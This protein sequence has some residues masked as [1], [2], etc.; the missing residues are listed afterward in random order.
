MRVFLIVLFVL[1]TVTMAEARPKRSLGIKTGPH[2]S[3][4]RYSVENDEDTDVHTFDYETTPSIAFFLDLQFNKNITHSFLMHYYQN[5]GSESVSIPLLFYARASRSIKLQ[6]IGGGYNFKATLPVEKFIPYFAAGISF[7][8]LMDNEIHGALGIG[9]ENVYNDTED[10]EIDKFTA[11]A[12]ILMGVEYNLE[13][14][15]LLLEYG[16]SYN[17]IPFY[18]W[19]N[20]NK[21]VKYSY[22]SFGHTI[23]FGVK[24]PF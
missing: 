14:V 19:E 7:D 10:D 22:T 16:F 1:S 17:L 3:T 23:S 21:T 4:I 9:G 6:Y 18:T 24:I 12:I 15:S 13:K 8:F 5:Y 2:F 20:D 11:Q